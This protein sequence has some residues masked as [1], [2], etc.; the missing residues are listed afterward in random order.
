MA[1]LLFTKNKQNTRHNPLAAFAKDNI[2]I[3]L[4]KRYHAESI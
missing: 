1:T 4:K 2:K 3:R